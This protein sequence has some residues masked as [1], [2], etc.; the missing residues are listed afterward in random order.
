MIGFTSIEDF[1]D[2]LDS[3]KNRLHSED[4]ER[5]LNAFKN[6]VNDYTG[7]TIYDVEYRL[8]TKNE[9][10]RWFHAAGNLISPQTYLITPKTSGPS[11]NVCIKLLKQ[12][13]TVFF[14]NI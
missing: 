10:W 13:F 7:K 8:M 9:G 11:R 6:A 1:P 2:E 5:V 4:K 12:F 14:R 3:W